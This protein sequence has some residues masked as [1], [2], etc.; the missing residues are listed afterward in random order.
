MT[1][2]A[3]PF[4]LLLGLI[5][6]LAGCQ[7]I[8][9]I[10]EV[11]RQIER[12]LPDARFEPEVHIRLGRMRLGLLRSLLRLV[13]DEGETVSILREVDRIEVATYQVES[14]PDLDETLP[15]LRFEDQLSQAGW[16]TTLRQQDGDSRTWLFT[17]ADDAGTM[18]NLYVV[19]LDPSELTLVR[20]EGRLDR[21]FAEAVA[22][23]PD[24]VVR[25]VSE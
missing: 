4:L 2:K 19:A 15:A 7:R 14:L 1:R 8:P 11:R 16:T 20:L 12:R 23:D 10:D 18:R 24:E 25:I 21:V 17:R 22:D 5:I 3:L 6:P 9:P 13:P